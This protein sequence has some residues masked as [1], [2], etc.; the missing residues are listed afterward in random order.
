MALKIQKNKVKV[1]IFS[2][3][4]AILGIKGVGK[5][6]LAFQVCEK[7]VPES[8]VI[9]NMGKEDG[10]KTLPNAI[11]ADIPE[12]SDFEDAVDEIVDERSTT[13]KDLKVVV[14]DTIDEMFAAAEREVIRLS[15]KAGKKCSTINEAWSG[16]GA[17]LSKTVELVTDNLWKLK[18]AGISI[19]YIGHVRSKTLVDPISDL[20]YE[21]IGSTLSNKYFDAIADKM[22]VIGVCYI[23]RDIAKEISKRK[24][25]KGKNIEHSVVKDEVRKICFRSTNYVAES[26][27][28]FP[29]IVETINLDADEFIKA[30]EDAIQDLIDRSGYTKDQ[31]K[32]EQDAEAAKRTA[33]IAE[34]EA[35]RAT[36]KELNSILSQIKDFFI[37]HKDN[38]D[39]LKPI[40]QEVKSMG[41]DK[42]MDITNIEEAK[43]ILSMCE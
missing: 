34:A 30:I 5:S 7:L 13:Y 36:E 24:N 10:I 14:I 33:E 40:M 18:N 6:T 31:L 1:D 21:T 41:Y 12:F 15:N 2:Y 11:Y 42:P 35:K 27:S 3:N 20:Q 29:N 43:K 37:D 8:Y 22:D 32:K 28:R 23:D 25:I 19:F 38:R 17:G 39:V 4:L 9:F 26:K 16:W